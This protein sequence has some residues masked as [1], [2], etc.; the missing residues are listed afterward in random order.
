MTLNYLLEIHIC[1]KLISILINN[2][3]TIQNEK[4]LS[5]EMISNNQ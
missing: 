4:I 5:A 1:K 2:T 3:Q